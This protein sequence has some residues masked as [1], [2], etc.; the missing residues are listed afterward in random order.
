MEKLGKTKNRKAEDGEV[1]PR[2]KAS[3]LDT[4]VYLREKAEREFDLRKRRTGS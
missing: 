4:L 1:T 3:G 2:K